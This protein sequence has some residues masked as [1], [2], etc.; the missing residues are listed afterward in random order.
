MKNLI[1]VALFLVF[2][3]AISFSSNA[4][5]KN[6]EGDFVHV[7]YFWFKNPDNQEGRKNFEAS[8]KKFLDSSRHI[9][10]KYVGT[11]ANTPRE[12]VDNSYT[13][14]L[15]VTF[16]SKE[17]HDKYQ[18]EEVHKKFIEESGHLWERVQIYDSVSIL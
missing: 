11:P 8:L 5:N 9:K 10:S 6:V 2:F 14:C 15:V 4:Q 18:E 17:E 7:V 16:D 3:A 13:Y 12:V 1:K